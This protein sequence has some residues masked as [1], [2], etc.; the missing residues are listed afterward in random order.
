MQVLDPDNPNEETLR[1]LGTMADTTQD[2]LVIKTIKV[3]KQ[4]GADHKSF[5]FY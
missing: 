4:T 2:E 5:F 1:R 3:D